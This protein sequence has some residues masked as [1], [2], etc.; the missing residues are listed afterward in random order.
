MSKREEDIMKKLMAMLMVG[1]LS[2]SMLVGCGNDTTA[3]ETTAQETETTETEATEE[4]ASEGD[5]YTVG[6]IQ[7]VEHQALDAAT[8]GFETALTDKLGDKVTFDYQNAQGESTNCATI[9]TKFVNDGV[10]LIMA[11]ATSALQSAAAATNEIPIV[12]TS[13]TDF[14]TANVVNSNEEPGT[15]VTGVSDLAPVDEQ[16]ALLQRVCP[17]V[18]KVAIVYCS[19]EA[20]SVFQ[21][22]LAA[23]YLDAAGIA[24]KVYTAADSNEIQAVIT[25]AVADCDCVYIPTDNTFADNMEIVKN[26]TV[27]AGIPVICGEENMCSVGGLATLSISYYDLGYKAGEMAYEILVNGADPATMPIGFVSDGIVAK[28]NAEIADSINWTIPEDLVAIESSEE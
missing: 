10:D 28:Y 19:S 16:I 22:D 3:E 6:I 17:D 11:N 13:V 25:S 5:T 21:A 9:S 26:V 2:V 12:G 20:N 1:I 24:Y 18:T 14:V 23:E 27:P 4:T 8:E 15:N 7:L